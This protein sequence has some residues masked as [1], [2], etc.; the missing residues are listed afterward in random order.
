MTLMSHSDKGVI[1]HNRWP[2]QK[3]KSGAKQ[4]G[5][6]TCCLIIT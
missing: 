3:Q 6:K 2:Y 4:I 5:Y 1:T